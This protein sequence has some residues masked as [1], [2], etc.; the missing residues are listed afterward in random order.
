MV[1]HLWLAVWLAVSVGSLAGADK[2]VIPTSSANPAIPA[3]STLHCRL[4][5][6]LSTKLNFQGDLFTA[7]VSEPL[8]VSGREAIPVGATVEGRVSWLARPGRL[9]GV[10]EMRLVAEKLTLPNGRSFPL[11]ALL[12]SAYGAEGA[13]VSGDEGIVKG[14]SS[15]FKSF[16]EI[17]A[18]A[19]GGGVVGLIFAHPVLGMAL[20]GAA[21]V[22]DRA[23][24]RGAD[25]NLPQGTQLNYQLTRELVVQR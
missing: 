8:M 2:Q 6:T 9:K 22:V 23:R 17:G 21:G 5:Q 14:P 4:T 18:L 19:G 1:K 13:K 3:G 7:T 10:G 15:R 24:R 16:E 11:N 12:L 25:L 20:G